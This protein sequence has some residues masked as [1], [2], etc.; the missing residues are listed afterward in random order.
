VFFT[1]WSRQ[2]TEELNIEVIAGMVR[3]LV[4]ALAHAPVR[5]VALVTGLKH[6][7]GPFEAYGQGA[8]PDSIF[9]EDEPR[10]D[11]ANFYAKLVF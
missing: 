7:L 1:A 4:A 3:D 8:M 11:V 6:Y 10:L 2:A 9:S 5:H